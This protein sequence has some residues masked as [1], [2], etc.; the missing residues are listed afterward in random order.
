MNLPANY[1]TSKYLLYELIGAALV[2]IELIIL[3]TKGYIRFHWVTDTLWLFSAVLLVVPELTKDKPLMKYPAW[4]SAI[5]TPLLLGLY[6]CLYHLFAALFSLR[7]IDLEFLLQAAAAV[8]FTMAL[9]GRANEAG[10]SIKTF[11]WKNLLRYP[12]WPFSIGIILCQL[13][14]FFPM[15]ESTSLRSSY[16]PQFG[17]N[18]YDGYSYN[19]WGY[20]YYGIHIII[21]GYLAYWG[22][23]ACILLG[24]ILVFHVIRS[25][26]NKVYP[27]MELFFK[28]AVPTI[29][30]W[31]IFGAKG[32][33]A[34][35]GLGNIL[36]IPGMLL[37][38]L[39]TY[40]PGQL[41]EWIKKKGLV[42]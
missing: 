36:F 3:L 18:A 15:I 39:A 23:F 29:L 42:K 33:N 27:Q 19:N 26:G 16:G 4:Q 20:S 25:A 14:I 12:D 38:M 31:W 6:L 35:K 21:K 34:L 24:S 9:N 28:V 40:I 10:I 32:Y 7:H 8:L 13:A 11:D 17:Y 37:L 22:H 1:K 5:T 30:A 41:G 2:L